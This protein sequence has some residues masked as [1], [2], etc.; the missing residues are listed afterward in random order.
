MLD[1]RIPAAISCFVKISAYREIRTQRR[2]SLVQPCRRQ[3]L[4]SGA[5]ASAEPWGRPC[6]RMRVP[7]GTRPPHQA[8]VCTSVPVGSRTPWSYTLVSDAP[9]IVSRPSCPREACM[10]LAAAGLESRRISR[11]LARLRRSPLCVAA[12][13]STSSGLLWP[14][15]CLGFTSS[16]LSSLHAA[17]CVL[18]RTADLH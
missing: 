12:F 8:V 14:Q 9:C 15:S 16:C 6:T 18:K 10:Q 11:I 3:A 2:C 4:G 13:L 5:R 7:N 1:E 17:E